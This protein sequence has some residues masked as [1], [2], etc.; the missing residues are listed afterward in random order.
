MSRRYDVEGTRGFLLASIV[1]LVLTLWFGWDGWFPRESVRAAH[2][3][4]DDSFYLFNQV[5]A[6]I[7]LV[8]AIVCAYIH[9][10]VK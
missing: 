2:P 8:A 3:S 5:C 9:T 4:P 6:V 10:V 7:F 1:L